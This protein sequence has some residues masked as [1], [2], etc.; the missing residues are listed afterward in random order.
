[1]RNQRVDGPTVTT[2]L[3]REIDAASRMSAPFVSTRIPVEP[4]WLDG[5]GH[6]N[7]AYYLVVSERGLDQAWSAMGIGWEYARESGLST[8]AAETHIRYLRELPGGSALEV[9]FQVLEVDE[10]RLRGVSEIREV[11]NGAVAATTEQ[12]WLHVDLGTR[13]VAP[14][15]RPIRRRLEAWRAAHS[16]LPVPAWAGR[17]IAMRRP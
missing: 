4:G 11:A 3:D 13:R 8:F 15:P 17:G 16:G 2:I 9:T 12:V 10:K 6:M 14:W 1:M 7:M 5:N